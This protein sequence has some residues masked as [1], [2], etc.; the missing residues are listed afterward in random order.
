MLSWLFL[1][2]VRGR[3][4]SLQSLP[5]PCPADL[6]LPAALTRLES[7]PP[8]P[9]RFVGSLPGLQL[10]KL[11]PCLLALTF[12]ASSCPPLAIPHHAPPCSHITPSFVP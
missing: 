9:L 6:C 11:S 12:A 5:A 8:W 3:F 1:F 7:L 4:L 10:L 2:T